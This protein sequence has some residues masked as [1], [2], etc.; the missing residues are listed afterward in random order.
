MKYVTEIVNRGPLRAT[1][2]E[3]LKTLGLKVPKCRKISMKQDIKTNG[4][5]F[6]APINHLPFVIVDEDNKRMKIPSFFATILSC[7]EKGIE[8]EGLFRKAGSVMRQREIRKKVEKGV[9]DFDMT[10]AYDLASLVKQFLRELPEPL[11][12]SRF[13][14]A[15]LK[16][17]TFAED[18]RF[19]CIMLLC[20]LL[21]VEHINLLRYVM[22]FLKR[23][24]SFSDKNKMDV[25]NLSLIMAPN[26]MQIIEKS[27]KCSKILE[28]QTGIISILIKNAE[29]IGLV[30]HTIMEKLNTNQSGDD[31]VGSSSF[32]STLA[33]SKR[34]NSLNGVLHSIRKRAAHRQALSEAKDQ[35][36]LSLY[37][38]F[39]DTPR[40][41]SP[42]KLE[43]RHSSKRKAD[44]DES[45]VTPIKKR[46]MSDNCETSF[47][48]PASQF[49]NSKTNQTHLDTVRPSENALFVGT[50]NISFTN[51]S[52][53]VFTP[54]KNMLKTPKSKSSKYKRFFSPAK[55]IRRQK[56]CS[57]AVN[58]E[59]SLQEVCKHVIVLSNFTHL[60]PIVSQCEDTSRFHHHV[61]TKTAPSHFEC[62]TVPIINFANPHVV[63]FGTNNVQLNEI[64]SLDESIDKT[65]DDEAKM[66]NVAYEMLSYALKSR[67]S[68]TDTDLCRLA[69][70]SASPISKKRNLPVKT[71][72]LRRGKPNTI[73][74]GLPMASP[75]KTSNLNIPSNDKENVIETSTSIN[76]IKPMVVFDFSP[77]P[78]PV[79]AR[80][81]LEYDV[82]TTKIKPI[83]V[84]INA[85]IEPNWQNHIEKTS[86]EEKVDEDWREKLAKVKESEEKTAE[87]KENVKK[88][89]QNERK[90]SEIDENGEENDEISPQEENPRIQSPHNRPTFSQPDIHVTT[91]RSNS[92]CVPLT[93]KTRHLLENAGFSHEEESTKGS[94]E[95]QLVWQSAA[96]VLNEEF[97][98]KC[99]RPS[100]LMIKTERAGS[101]LQNIKKYNAITKCEDVKTPRSFRVRNKTPIQTRIKM[102][103]ANSA[104]PPIRC[105][106][107]STTP[108]SSANRCNSFSATPSSLPRVAVLRSVSSTP[109]LASNNSSRSP[110]KPRNDM[111]IQTPSTVFKTPLLLP[112]TPKTTPKQQRSSIKGARNGFQRGSVQ[113]SPFT[114]IMT[115]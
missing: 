111:Q 97:A 47:L 4:K 31:L 103:A 89:S 61:E 9:M 81:S 27:D 88:H 86:S 8:S 3:E 78:K 40:E 110:L 7:L 52:A 62:S 5:V 24:A 42:K 71:K 69:T 101:V 55:L 18:K 66:S 74:T 102:E 39:N 83:V 114:P 37:N 108:K 17:Q 34:R 113:S 77:S 49:G 63:P 104:T 94:T 12:F 25:H 79:K 57:A 32:D 98:T 36:P 2:R 72:S 46:I 51:P 112:K 90:L 56:C 95:Q 82:T 64:S 28:S 10:P 109:S 67:R 92:P 44:K 58:S 65:E 84:Q 87:T 15:F 96:D 6:G 85:K 16:A 70:D 80:K 93:R 30:P 11:I 35:V 20:L 21:P 48:T 54:T 107:F 1:V 33:K 50:P 13:H 68:L 60:T 76:G 45:S 23:L 22:S 19:T 59:L 105:S 38:N 106:S 115:K 41:N 14:D 29:D 73:R 99:S 26:L 53:N 75:F 91:R 100:L 43:K